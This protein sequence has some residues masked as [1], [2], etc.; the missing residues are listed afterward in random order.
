MLVFINTINHKFISLLT[1]VQKQPKRNYEGPKPTTSHIQT[2]KL[3][4]VEALTPGPTTP[5][6][7]PVGQ[8]QLQV[9]TSLTVNGS[10]CNSR[11][12]Q[13]PWE[14]SYSNQEEQNPFCLR[15][16]LQ[17]LYPGANGG[18][19][20]HFFG[21]PRIP[22]QVQPSIQ[23]TPTKGSRLLQLDSPWPLTS[24]QICTNRLIPRIRLSEHSPD[25]LELVEKKQFGSCS[26][27]NKL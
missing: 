19:L 2:D 22:F 4:A 15:P 1:Q 18:P 27:I 23:G 11:A 25:S 21:H 7:G 3:V 12:H 20:D 26:I 9:I 14:S 16:Q 6:P 24:L 10:A 8:A 5:S 13:P 17:I